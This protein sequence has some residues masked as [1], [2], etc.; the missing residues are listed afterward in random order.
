VLILGK[1][2]YPLKLS[3]YINRA[4]VLCLITDVFLK[5]A[6]WSWRQ[7]LADT[8]ASRLKGKYRTTKRYI[9]LMKFLALPVTNNL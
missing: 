9:L 5:L 3:A 2:K 6:S 4:A 7:F 1:Q 8:R